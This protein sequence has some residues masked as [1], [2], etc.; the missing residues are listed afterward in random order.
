MKLYDVNVFLAFENI[1]TLDLLNIKIQLI[2]TAANLFLLKKKKNSTTARRNI[3]CI[4]S[5]KKNSNVI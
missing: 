3:F 4:K 2:K 1:T 5:L